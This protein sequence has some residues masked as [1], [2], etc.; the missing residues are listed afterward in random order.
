MDGHFWLCTWS[1]L[2]TLHRRVAITPSH[3]EFLELES[4]LGKTMLVVNE[5]LGYFFWPIHSIG[6]EL[7]SIG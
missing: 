7:L 4:L 3:P 1:L 6:S 5:K 2:P